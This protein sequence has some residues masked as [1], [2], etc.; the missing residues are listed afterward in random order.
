MNS[1]FM[2]AKKTWYLSPFNTVDFT[3]AVAIALVNELVSK[4]YAV[5]WNGIFI[6][7]SIHF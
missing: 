7:Q 6:Q 1:V 4:L 3:E 5:E 2:L